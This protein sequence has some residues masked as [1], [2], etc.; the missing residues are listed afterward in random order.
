MDIAQFKKASPMAGTLRM[1]RMA[2]IWC[3]GCGIGSEV[4]SFAEAV[5]RSGID[6]AKLAVVSGIGCTGRV[7]GYVDFDSIHTT[8]GRAIPV[9]TGLKLARPDMKVVVFSGEGDLTGIGGNHFIHAAR[10]NM[11]I[12]VICNNNFTYG[13]TGGQVT[14]TTPG[15]AIS[16]TTPFG[17][18]EYPFN[19]PFLAEAAGATYIARWTSMHSRN[20]IQSIEEALSRKGFSFIE[21]ISPCTTLYLRRN[22]L[23]DGVDM[24][25]FYQENAVLQHGA[26]TRTLDIDFQSK[27]VIGKFVEKDKPDYITA[28]DNRCVKVVGDD[29]QLYGKTVPEREAEEKAEKERIAARRAAAAAEAEAQE[30][31]VAKKAAAPAKKPAAKPAAKKA[32]ATRAPAKKAAAAKPAAKAA[33]KKSAAKSA[34]TAKK[35]AAKP[36]AKKAAVK[37]SAAKPAAKKTTRK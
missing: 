36:V 13:M 4:N 1:D 23:G 2:H 35:V 20:L 12:V 32:V 37:K 6:P 27:I 8:H 22:R 3:P 21:V 14:P 16:S 7:A 24:L 33:V 11:D 17:N 18:H 30:K 10:R 28:L 34:A 29:Y 31:K 26:D 5:K 15:G 19:L 9:A 25:Q